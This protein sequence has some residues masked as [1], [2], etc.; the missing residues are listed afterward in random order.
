[1]VFKPAFK[2]LSSKISLLGVFNKM[3]S[4]MSLHSPNNTIYTSTLTT[5]SLI[6]RESPFS[7]EETHIF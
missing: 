7:V 3:I 5:A 4:N 1:M 2:A 6:Y